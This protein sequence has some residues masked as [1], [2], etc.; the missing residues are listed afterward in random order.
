[1]ATKAIELERLADGQGCL[2]RADDDEPLFI[3]RAQDRL[4]APLVRL[5]ADLA[6][7]L[8]CPKALEAHSLAD[9]MERWG[10]AHPDR[11][12]WPD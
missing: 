6:H 1:M 12:K 3:L 7:R 9:E 4:A 10:I 11:L 5:W 2:G 8:G